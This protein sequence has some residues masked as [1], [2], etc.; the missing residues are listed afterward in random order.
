MNLANFLMSACQGRIIIIGV[1]PR[2]DG[3]NDAI[4]ELI[5]LLAIDKRFGYKFVGCGCSLS[6]KSVLGL[7]KVHLQEEGK[8]K[9]KRVINNKITR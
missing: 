3:T 5:S 9:L 6:N 8:L 1:P 2:H 7:D 4:R